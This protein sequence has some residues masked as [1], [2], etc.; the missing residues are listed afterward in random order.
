MNEQVNDESILFNP[1]YFVACIIQ[2]K[3]SVV[4]SDP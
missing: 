3:K 4:T 1:G 2:L